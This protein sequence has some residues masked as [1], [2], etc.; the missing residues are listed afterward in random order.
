MAEQLQPLSGEIRPELT[1][2]CFHCGDDCR[3]N[4]ID[5]DDR[6]FCCSGCLSV[7]RLL[8][9]NRLTTYYSLESCPGKRPLSEDASRRFGWLDDSATVGRLLDVSLDGHCR[10]TLSIP[11]VHCSSC[12]WLLEKLFQMND[13]IKSSQLDLLRK[14]LVVTFDNRRIPLRGVVELLVKIGYEPH[15]DLASLDKP[16]RKTS[17]KS[18]YMKIGLAGFAFGNI[19]LFSFPEYLA[20]H[21]LTETLFGR[22]F[23]YFNLFL[24]IPVLL[25]SARDF[26]ISSWNGLRNKSINIDL[27]I[28]LGL[29][30]LF[31]RS[32][33]EVTFGLGAGYFDSFSGLVF[34]LL[35]GRLFQAKTYHALSFDRDY[36]SYLPVGVVRRTATGEEVVPADSLV[37]GDK[38]IIRNQEL[39]PVDGILIEGEGCVDYSFLTGESAPQTIQHGER[40]MAGGR[41]TGGAVVIMATKEVSS[42]YLARLW[43]ADCFHQ[44][45]ESRVVAAANIAAKYFTI[46]VLAI[47]VA[48][49]LFWWRVNPSMIL[50]AVTAVLMVACPCALA[51]ASPYVFGTAMRFLGR[52]GCYLRSA[53]TVEQLA[54]TTHVIF[55]KTGTLTYADSGESATAKSAMSHYHRSLVISLARQSVHP[56]SR[57]ICRMFG[58]AKSIPVTQFEEI[59][60][61]G[62]QGKVDGHLVRIG[63]Y[64]WASRKGAVAGNADNRPAGSGV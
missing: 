8:S 37:S 9:R 59:P 63:S 38:V 58:N 42:S 23:G 3:G 28:A 52:N 36:R 39:I 41:Q 33:V 64:E 17:F 24:S 51:M 57:S 2:V 43:R 31:G 21:G 46:A 60:G 54:Q 7:Y 55:D 47:A 56:V 18:L 62:T 5:H 15:I 22:V 50:N 34:F 27:P 6:Q 16:V 14:E 13:G 35:L 49:V 26:F 45:R 4:G 12:V 61:K 11:H 1:G 44:P 48:T 53:G 10:V 19:M 20:S 25:Y 29:L 40:V 30:A 32:A